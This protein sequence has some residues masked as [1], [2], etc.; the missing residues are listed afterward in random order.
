MSLILKPL[1]TPLNLNL[2]KR[3]HNPRENFGVT[4]V[5]IKELF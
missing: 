2:I 5:V 1:L 4:A 3:L